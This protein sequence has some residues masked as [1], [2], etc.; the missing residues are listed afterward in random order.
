MRIT[1]AAHY[2]GISINTLKE[3]ADTGLKIARESIENK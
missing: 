1:E 3:M 2:L